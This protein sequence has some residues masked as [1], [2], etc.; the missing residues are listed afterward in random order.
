MLDG[1]LLKM[2]LLSYF[3]T[4]DGTKLPPIPFPVMYTPESFSKSLTVDYQCKG[5]PGDDRNELSFY[6]TSTGDVSF[7]FLFDATGASKNGIQ[8]EAA[9]LLG[10]VDVQ[11]ALFKKLTAE[12]NPGTH[13]PPK[14]TLVWGTFIFDCRLVSM[15]TNYTLF[16]SIGRPLRAKVSAKFKGDE[17]RSLISAIAKLFSADLTHV[18]LV[19]DGETL[20]AIAHQIYGDPKY[21]VEIARVNYLR[22]FRALKPG[23]ELILPPV[24]NL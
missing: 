14:L 19:K 6:K 18:H 2:L 12:R 10:G 13:E 9:A 8:S 17:P 23:M 1:K 5:G 22:I 16:N 24:N 21:Y 3:T 4:K 20:P 15:T 11:I 7:E